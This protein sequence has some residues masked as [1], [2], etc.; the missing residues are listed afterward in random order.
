MA[1]FRVWAPFASRVE[2]EL[3][4]ERHAM[5]PVGRG[6]HYLAAEAQHGDDYAFSLDEGELLPDPRSPWQPAGVF[7]R[8]R[9]VDHS[10][11]P[12]QDGSFRA[13]P[14]ASAIFYELHIGTFSPQRT[15]DGAAGRLPYLKDLGI[16]HIELMPVCEFPGD[17]NWG[18]DGVDLYAPHHSYGGP[19]GLKRFVDAAHRHDLAVVLDVVYN[20]LGPSGNTL[21]RFGPYFVSDVQTPWGEAINF[22]GRHSDE[23]RRFFLDNALMWFRDYHMDGLRLD[24]V[25]SYG[26]TSSYHF[27]EQLKDE[28]HMLEAHLQRPLVLVAESDQ[29][30]PR[31]VRPAEAGGYGIEAQWNDDFQHSLHSLLTGEQI[32]YFTDFG[33]FRTLSKALTQGFVHTGE[34]SS[35]RGRRHGRPLFNVPGSRLVGFLQNHDHAGNRCVGERSSHLMSTERLKIGAALVFTAPFLPLIFSGEEWGASTY[36][37]FFTSF[38]DPELAR[39]VTDGRRAEFPEFAAMGEVPDPQDPATFERS[40]LNWAEQDQEPHR[41]LLEWHRGLIQLRKKYLVLSNGNMDEAEI[42]YEED[43]RWMIMERDRLT[44]AL[45]LADGP[46]TLRLREGRATNIL[47]RSNEAIT[48]EEALLHFPAEGI[49]ILGPRW[50]DYHLF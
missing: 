31:I 11:Y 49:A 27:L 36:F 2:L 35:F 48:C 34:Y 5:H 43:D 29:N 10:L 47:L 14:L 38:E 18:Y 13:K 4:G 12:W 45:S 16:T 33:S 44:I 50:E 28:V 7:G 30:D 25:G 8:S 26:D 23:V 24:A 22:A 6:Y 32:S 42:I 41:S 17:R 46:V 1:L 3:R 39:A 40:T 15:F 19:D 9:F 21:G 20:H 37:Q